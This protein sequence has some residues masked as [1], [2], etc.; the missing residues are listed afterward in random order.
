MR[1]EVIDMQLPLNGDMLI[2]Y[3]LAYSSADCE[4]HYGSTTRPKKS[5][6]VAA[7]LWT[8]PLQATESTVYQEPNLFAGAQPHQHLS[9]RQTD[10]AGYSQ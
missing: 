1:S 2:R 6:G 10:K 9:F 5:K 4:N 3:S 7:K 8:R